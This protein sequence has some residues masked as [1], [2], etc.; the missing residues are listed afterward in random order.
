LIFALINLFALSP[1]ACTK[2]ADYVVSIRKAH[3]ENALS[4]PAK[5]EVPFF[6]GAVGMI[7][8]DNATRICKGE[9]RFR[10]RHAMLFLILA[11]L[12]RIPC[13]PSL[14]HVEA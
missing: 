1:V 7:F 3:R 14:G 5:A 11:I 6:H 12:L 13:E 10:E 4:D 8:R 9:L 2:Y